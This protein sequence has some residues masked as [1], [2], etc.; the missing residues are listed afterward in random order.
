MTPPP[1]TTPTWQTT[2]EV[3]ARIRRDPSGIRRAAEAGELHGHQ[4]LRD[5]RPIPGSRWTFSTAAVDAYVQ[6]LDIRAQRDACGCARHLRAV[7]A[8]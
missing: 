6:G 2:T 3:A 4:R 7:R 1:A 8:S 5:G